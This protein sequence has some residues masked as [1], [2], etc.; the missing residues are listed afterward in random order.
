M[1]SRYCRL[2]AV[3]MNSCYRKGLAYF[4]ANPVNYNT[5]K[6]LDETVAV[7]A[8]TQTTVQR[9][10]AAHGWP[11]LTSILGVDAWVGSP[12]THWIQ[13]A[14]H[15][16]LRGVFGICFDH[17]TCDTS[18]YHEGAPWEC[19]R[20]QPDNFRYPSSNP[21][22]LWAFPWTMRDL[23]NSSWPMFAKVITA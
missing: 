8:A 12:G 14:A 1:V 16:G 6:T 22:D 13:A 19:Y 17:E 18:A 7:P 21:T 4:S 3:S 15:V 2:K 9:A 23:C 11:L 5:G 10:F 20:M